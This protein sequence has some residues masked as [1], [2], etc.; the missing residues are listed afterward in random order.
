[1]WCAGSLVPQKNKWRLWKDTATTDFDTFH[2]RQLAALT[3]L[4]RNCVPRS[5]ILSGP[6]RWGCRGIIFAIVCS[7]M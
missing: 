4:I 2:D 7:G 6:F 3:T 5:S 1:M